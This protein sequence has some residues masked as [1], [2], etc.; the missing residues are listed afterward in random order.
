MRSHPGPRTGGGDD[1]EKNTVSK[2]THLYASVPAQSEKAHAH[3]HH[4]NQ[5]LRLL[6][7]TCH[8][9]FLKSLHR[10]L[11]ASYGHPGP[12]V[13]LPF[14]HPRSLHWHMP[15]KRKPY[16]LRRPSRYTSMKKPINHL[17]ALPPSPLDAAKA[18]ILPHSL[19]S[20]VAVQ[21]QQAQ[22]PLVLNATSWTCQM[23]KT[24]KIAYTL[25]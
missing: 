9:C 14:V 5:P 10:S 3:Y 4:P 11:N 2:Q 6:S 17:D 7:P 16:S 20:R 12:R 24:T 8:Q 21:H 18:T 22:S 1:R 13:F 23:T 15:C 19:V 25:V